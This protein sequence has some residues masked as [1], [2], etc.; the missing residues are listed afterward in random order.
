MALK[1]LDRGTSKLDVH[2]LSKLCQVAVEHLKTHEELPS[3]DKCT[4]EVIKILL[5]INENKAPISD[6][7]VLVFAE[8]MSMYPN[9]DLTDALE[10]VKKTS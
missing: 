6:S 3:R 1:G 10:F 5:F 7:G 4:N 9:V 2:S 8:I